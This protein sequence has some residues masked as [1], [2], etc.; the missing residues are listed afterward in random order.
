ML[1]HY[2][3]LHLGE[4]WYEPQAR[5]LVML[6][7]ALHLFQDAGKDCTASGWCLPNFV[8]GSIN[9][10]DVRL[11]SILLTNNRL[12]HVW[13]PCKPFLRHITN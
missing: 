11:Q 13:C 9:R 3:L 1:G 8:P 12:A 5:C 4:P 7:A 10:P 2:F 6:P